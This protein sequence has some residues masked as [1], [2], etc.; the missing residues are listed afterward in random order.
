MGIKNIQLPLRD[1][2]IASLRAG[3][4]VLLNG[5]V[6]TARDQVHFRLVD[7]FAKKKMPMDLKGQKRQNVHQG[8]LATSARSE[9][10]HDYPAWNVERKVMQNVILAPPNV[11]LRTFNSRGHPPHLTTAGWAGGSVFRCQHS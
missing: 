7:A 4:E 11:E 9:K 6:Y 1:K 8:R 10:P 2:D 5:Y 3:D